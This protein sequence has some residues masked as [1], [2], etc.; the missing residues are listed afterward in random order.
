MGHA[1]LVHEAW[2]ALARGDFAAVESVL[3]PDASWRAVEDGPWNCEGRAQIIGVMRERHARSGGL[4]GDVVEVLD[5]GARVLVAFRP[6]RPEP[7]Q[8][9]LDDGLRYV[10][11]SIDSGRIME[12]KGCSGREAALAYAGAPG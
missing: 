8:W 7:G 9:P 2:G 4:D 12:M 11:L 10:V 3:A 6:A 5:V 1:R